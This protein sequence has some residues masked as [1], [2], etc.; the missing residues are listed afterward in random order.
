MFI[1]YLL[2]CIN[3]YISI[4]SARGNFVAPSQLHDIQYFNCK[5]HKNFQN[6]A[7]VGHQEMSHCFLDCVANYGAGH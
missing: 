4:L 2:R 3:A 1:A 5:I 7:L 6:G